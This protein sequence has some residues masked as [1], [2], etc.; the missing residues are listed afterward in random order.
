LRKLA[1][2]TNQFMLI[3]RKDTSGIG[4]VRNSVCEAIY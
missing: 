2:R 3:Y 1:T 4:G